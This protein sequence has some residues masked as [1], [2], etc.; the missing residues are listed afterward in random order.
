MTRVRFKRTIVREM[1]TAQIAETIWPKA[2]REIIGLLFTR[3]DE[4]WHLRDIARLTDLAPATVQRE[5]VSLSDAGILTRR[6]SGNQVFYS[7]D[8]ECPIFDELQ[9]IAIKTVGVAS[10]IR[11][12]L[13][14]MTDRI[15]VA[16]VF[17]SIASGDARPDSD[18]DLMII[19]DA[20]L[21]ELSPRLRDLEKTLG[22]D[23]NPITMG[24]DELARRIAEREHFVSRVLGEP[25]V[26]ILGDDHELERLAGT[27][28][29]APAQRAPE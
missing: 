20:G 3:P 1:R 15:A 26:F 17:G 7:A 23:V 2:R 22:R 24:P 11:E 10:P 27:R 12:V 6:S 4:E 16:F 14:D 9:G 29:T 8:R 5:V 18:I 21:R 13:E 25:K 28:A 19:G